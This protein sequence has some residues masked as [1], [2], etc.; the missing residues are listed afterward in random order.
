[1]RLLGWTR[2]GRHEVTSCVTDLVLGVRGFVLD[3]QRFSNNALVLKI[4]LPADRFE[5]FI[6]GLNECSVTLD[7]D[8]YAVLESAAS[9][10][11]VGT[12]HVRFVHDEPDL[13][14]DTPAVPG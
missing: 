9:D 10:E 4:Q 12:L 2:S 13:R 11:V 14:I 8:P 1:M 6:T 3:S 5:Q 7:G